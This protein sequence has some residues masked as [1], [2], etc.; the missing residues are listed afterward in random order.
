LIDM[1]I[2]TFNVLVLY[3]V[4][5]GFSIPVSLARQAALSHDLTTSPTS[6]TTQQHHSPTPTLNTSKFKYSLNDPF[7]IFAPP[8]DPICCLIP[9]PTAQPD[10]HPAGE[11]LPFEEWKEKQQALSSAEA[12]RVDEANGI[13]TAVAHLSDESAAVP[14]TTGNIL[15]PV[16]E[17]SDSP[18]SR[19]IG[20]FVPIQGRFN[21]A[22]L[23]CSARVH[24]SHKSMKSAHSILFSKKDKYMLTPC[25]AKGKVP[26]I[27]GSTSNLHIFSNKR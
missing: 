3:S 23:D 15:I 12:R 1:S 20:E 16:I 22:S 17:T 14:E 21:Y 11:L 18:P 6:Q 7:R 27:W 2:K 9:L 26:F 13:P 24:S 8:S 19:P 5:F 10:P 4:L 25:S